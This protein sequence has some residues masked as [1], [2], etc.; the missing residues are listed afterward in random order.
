ME[1]GEKIG[2]YL[3]RI[4][5]N[6]IDKPCRKDG[7]TLENFLRRRY[8]NPE[9]E[10]CTGCELSYKF[11]ATPTLALAERMLKVDRDWIS[12][13]LKG[14]YGESWLKG[15]ASIARGVKEFGIREPFTP[16][17]P[18]LVVW[19]LT[20]KCN[21]RCKHCYEDAGKERV[22]MGESEAR[23]ALEKLIDANVSAIAFSGGE[24]LV[25]KDFFELAK[26]AKKAGLYVSV[27]SN[28]T[29]ID[30]KM[31]RKLREVADYVEIS[32][33][34]LSE[35]HDTFRGIPGAFER[36]LN[37]VKHCLNEGIDVCIATT[38][39]RGN[40]EDILKVAQMANDLGARFIHFNYIPVGRGRKE[41]DISPKER[42]DLLEELARRNL[43]N[44]VKLG[45]GDLILSTAPQFGRKT[46]E[47]AQLQGIDYLVS[48]HYGGI[49]LPIEKLR[50]IESTANFIGGCGAG[51]LYLAME[52]NGDLLPC[53][54]FPREVKLGN[55]LEDDLLE[56][57]KKDQILE[58]LRDRKK[59]WYF[60]KENRK[61]GCGACEDKLICGGCRA[62]ALAYF[63]NYLAPDPGCVRNAELIS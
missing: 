1:C 53:T 11:L 42:E 33:D 22:E 3:G 51:R 14:R 49:N 43:E 61:V 13:M 54:F 35:K 23:E 27:A 57:W 4:V 38:A 44:Y 12:S 26:R 50:S 2:S 25:R 24:P 21:L 6:S 59:L 62:R 45:R 41:L 5:I 47:V 39:W 20:Y 46:K 37:G 36:A 58:E 28:G 30:E 31:A 18:L 15:I 60:R 40:L 63:G 16:A 9:L 10:L 56:V 32:I 29:L 34:G 52:P 17:S 7:A 8:M 48:T 55:I 19:N